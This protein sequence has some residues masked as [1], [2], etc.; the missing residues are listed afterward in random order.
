MFDTHNRTQNYITITLALNSRRVNV[1][2]TSG[3][4]ALSPLS[5]GDLCVRTERSSGIERVCALVS[6]ARPVGRPPDERSGG[7]DERARV[8][9][10]RRMH[11]RSQMTRHFGACIM[12]VLVEKGWSG[13]GG[14]V[15]RQCPHSHVHFKIAIIRRRVCECVCATAK[16]IR[17][18]RSGC[19]AF[20]ASRNAIKLHG[21]SDFSAC[22]PADRPTG[23][24]Y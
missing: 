4:V 11:A 23:R 3:F 16:H 13:G 1:A 5:H 21:K 19:E 7:C 22:R 24:N 17:R 20:P 8:F 2:A 9:W 6:V 15:Q 10:G 12:C 14:G 18:C